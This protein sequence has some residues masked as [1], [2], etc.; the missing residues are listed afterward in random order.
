MLVYSLLHCGKIETRM[1]TYHCRIQYLYLMYYVYIER[2]NFSK[3]YISKLKFIKNFAHGIGIV[4]CVRVSESA[5]YVT[6]Q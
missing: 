2:F 6:T 5:S 1:L 4:T 3:K